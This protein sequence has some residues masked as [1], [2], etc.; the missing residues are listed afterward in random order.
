M[1]FIHHPAIM[2]SLVGCFIA[3]AAAAA[4][5]T[6]ADLQQLLDQ[7]QYRACLQQ[8]A[9]VLNLR[10]DAYDPFVLQMR[11]GECLLNLNDPTTA[12]FAYTAALNA[13]STPRKADDARVM[14]A[15]IN[16]S[17][18]TQY[19]PKSADAQP[20]N[21]VPFDTRVA[22][23][24]ALYKEQMAA[25][26][27]DLAAAQQ[28]SNLQPIISIIPAAQ[29]LH[30]LE[31]AATGKDVETRPMLVAIGNRARDLITAELGN[32]NNQ[33]GAIE[34]RANRLYASGQTGVTGPNGQLLLVGDIR[35]GLSADD[36][37]NLRDLL[38]YLDRI[39][40]A[41]QHGK[42][43]ARTFGGDGSAWDPIIDQA[44]KTIRHAQDV[45]AA[46]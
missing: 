38:S 29:S 13:A 30:A 44:D 15:L 20:I 32:L 16:A 43:V 22:A 6:E 19:F 11:R 36:R 14:I 40:N 27:R 45:L 39:A 23:I 24:Q 37:N 4:L 18:G 1:R 33:I 12:L 42:Q 21:I 5:P 26:A 3:V 9:R 28:A 2:F 35:M 7:K 8:T 17:R 41:C 25:G 46:E 34:E 10:N 31:I